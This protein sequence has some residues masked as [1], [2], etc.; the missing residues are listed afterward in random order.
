ML[1]ALVIQ[2]SVSLVERKERSGPAV[3]AQDEEYH[4]AR[5]P[6]DRQQPQEVVDL[7]DHLPYMSEEAS[8]RVQDEHDRMFPL[9][10][11]RSLYSRLS[12]VSSCRDL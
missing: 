5:D 7:Q 10:V 2:A 1:P 3:E 4:L 8:R 12:I 9:R 6:Y 11:G